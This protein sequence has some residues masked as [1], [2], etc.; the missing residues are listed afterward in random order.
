MPIFLL[1]HNVITINATAHKR[2]TAKL[3]TIPE[4]TQHLSWSYPGL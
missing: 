2:Y 1:K 3:L 4:T